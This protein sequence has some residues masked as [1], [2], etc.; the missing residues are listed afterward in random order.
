MCNYVYI[1]P[2]LPPP[3]LP[4]C[5]IM[6]V[7]AVYV[8]RCPPLKPLSVLLPCFPTKQGN[9]DAHSVASV[10]GKVLVK[11]D[12]GSVQENDRDIHTQEPATKVRRTEQVI[13]L[14][15]DSPNTRLDTASVGATRSILQGMLNFFRRNEPSPS[16]PLPTKSQPP[17][18]FSLRNIFLG[19]DHENQQQAQQ[20][21]LKQQ[22]QLLPPTRDTSENKENIPPV[23]QEQSSAVTALQ[24]FRQN[25]S[26]KRR[27]QESDKPKPTTGILSTP[28]LPRALTTA[29]VSAT[30]CWSSQTE[31][32]IQGQTDSP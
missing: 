32:N 20:Q 9:H 11:E 23:N 6:R 25:E 27:R 18:P 19:S 4:S 5:T 13:D 10:C 12:S 24:T 14:A 26:L 2:P 21:Q 17:V 1:H 8:H 28:E 3:D 29:L 31:I 15:S 22:D 7:S 30:C 16:I